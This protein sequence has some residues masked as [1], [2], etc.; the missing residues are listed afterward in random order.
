MLI[1]SGAPFVFLCSPSG[2]AIFFII[3][4]GPA[5]ITAA[6]ETTSEQ[7]EVNLA[8]CMIGYPSLRDGAFLLAREYPLFPPRKISP[9]AI[10]ITESFIDQVRSI[11]MAGYW[12]HSY[13][14]VYGPRL[15]FAHKHAKQ[16]L[17]QYPAI[18]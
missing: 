15:R 11:K 4:I 17:G 8:L 9:K 18:S 12:P 7:D 10:Y 5:W 2:C 6:K 3:K 14:R 13:L 1:L 16:E